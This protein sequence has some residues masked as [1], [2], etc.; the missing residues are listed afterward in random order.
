MA[1]EWPSQGQSAPATLLNTAT[2][3]YLDPNLYQLTLPD[4]HSFVVRQGKGLESLTDLSGN[5]LTVS[6]SGIQYQNPAVPGSAVGISFVRDAQGRIQS[7][8]DPLNNH[9]TY[10]YDAS[11]DLATFTDRETHAT[12]FTYHPV[13]PHHLAS[14]QD[15]LGRTPIRNEYFDD[16]RIKS[17]TDAL[18]NT[19]TYQHDVS[20]AQEIVTDR[21]NGI[22]VLEYDERGNVIRETSPVGKVIDRT[23]DARN[24]RLSETL[25]YDPASPPSP[26]PTTRY[27]Y[28]TQDNLLSMTDPKSNR[29]EYTYDAQKHVLTTKDP[30]G[31]Y[32]EN[33]Y[34][35]KGNL[36][37]T[38]SGATVLGGPALSRQ[39]LLLRR[40]GQRQ[41]PDRGGGGRDAGHELQL[42]HPRQR[43]DRDGCDGARLQLHLRRERQPQDP[44]HHPHD[45]R[46]HRRKRS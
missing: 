24:N 14:I 26:I 20:V 40:A 5:R 28:D 17:H 2:F 43:G 32:T 30:K 38:R 11:G 19:I 35:P 27:T 45:T 23:F 21:D 42:R 33:T 34:D 13:F 18:G 22:R 31:V 10:A 29:T 3:D 12:T 41:D 36:T 6:A 9:L 37:R 39:Q 46:R 44:D 16:G 7:I 1:S 8:T 4:G 25:P 15:P